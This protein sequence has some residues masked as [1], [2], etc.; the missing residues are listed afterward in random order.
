[1]A[2][3][4]VKSMVNLMDLLLQAFDLDIPDCKSTQNQVADH[5]S[6]LENTPLYG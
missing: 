4:N 6:H 2:K 5:L 1:M 3:K